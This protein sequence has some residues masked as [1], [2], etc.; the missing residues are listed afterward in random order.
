MIK[1]GKGGVNFSPQAAETVDG[2]S[3]WGGLVVV[4]HF[5]LCGRAKALDPVITRRT[6]NRN[7][8]GCVSTYNKNSPSERRT[9]Y[10][11]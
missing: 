2:G 11:S 3:C 10:S 6:R 8:C 4:N 9:L 5:L 7:Y 1:L